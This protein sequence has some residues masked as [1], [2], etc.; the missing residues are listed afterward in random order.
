MRTVS[1]LHAGRSQLA[2]WFALP[3]LLSMLLLA[4]VSWRPVRE[5]LALRGTRSQA[6]D[7]RER[8]AEAERRQRSFEEQGTSSAIDGALA[9]ARGGVP[10]AASPL[11][12]HSVVRLIA[13]ALGFAL[14]SVVV[15]DATDPGLAVLDDA[16]LARPV[17]L[18]GS[19]PLDSIQRLNTALRAVGFRVGAT[20]FEARRSD[21]RSDRFQIHAEITFY[22]STEPGDPAVSELPGAESAPM[23]PPT[24]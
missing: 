16:V 9:Q 15:Q 24:Q 12:L 22:E 14:E 10:R 13:D 1:N 17:V 21:S 3:A 19:G 7:L 5:A 4:G 6:T 18:T 2:A 20:R 23:G 11:E 8:L